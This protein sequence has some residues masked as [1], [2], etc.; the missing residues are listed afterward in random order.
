MLEN[1][2]VIDIETPNVNGDS[3]CQ[4]AVQEVCDRRLVREFCSL[5]NP[6]DY[7]DM[8]CIQ[9]HGIAPQD[10]E[11]SPRLEELWPI[12]S[13][14]CTNTVLVAHNAIF[15][16]SV[17]S[18]SLAKSGINFNNIPYLCTYRLAHRLL[19]EGCENKNVNPMFSG[20]G[21]E[22]PEPT[23][24][25]HFGL[26]ALCEL[27]NIEMRRHH[28]ALS[29]AQACRQLLECLRGEGRLIPED[30]REYRN[31]DSLRAF[32]AG[33][34]GEV[35]FRRHLLG[36]AGTRYCLTGKFVCGS[37]KHVKELLHESGGLVL[38]TLRIDT[39]FLV[40]GGLRKSGTPPSSKLSKAEN[41]VLQG[42]PLQIIDEADVPMLRLH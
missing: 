11:N 37:R 6:Q 4:I 27:Y 1:Y 24:R 30:I 3:L 15:D 20:E 14:Y 5:V 18:K 7:F 42:H 31:L 21:I 32:N 40:V 8:R 16:V 38:D 9:V 33:A 10:V 22:K 41:M 35:A 12:L 39:D 34:E 26:K 23:G 13:S 2:T 17:L 28:D 36:E 25:R 19:R 29:D